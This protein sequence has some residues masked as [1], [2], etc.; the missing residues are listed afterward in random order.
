M[1]A[2]TASTTVIVLADSALRGAAW[3]ALLTVQP[4][5]AV[6][7][8]VVAPAGVST[9][10]PGEAAALLID[11]PQPQ[12]ALIRQLHALAA[13]TGLLCLV[14]SYDLAEILPLL[15]AGASGGVAHDASVGELARALI[16]VGRGEIALPPAVAARVLTALARGTPAAGSPLEPL[17]EREGAVLRL[18]ARGLTNKDIAQ[19]LLLSVRTVEAHLRSIFAKLGVQSRT[20]A[21]L[22]A[23]KH[24]YGP[25][26]R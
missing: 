16:A 6:T 25:D 20:E 22:W 18:L 1:M 9:L 23:V 12:P 10:R 15:Q 5:L 21:A 14:G 4:G 3:R 11:L 26:S 17:S 13:E 7:R 8:T 2:S 19:T 24:H